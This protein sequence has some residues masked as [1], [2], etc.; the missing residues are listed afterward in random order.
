VKIPTSL[1]F[2]FWSQYLDVLRLD[3]VSKISQQFPLA[4]QT[5][6]RNRDYRILIPPTLWSGM[7]LA[8][9]SIQ[10]LAEDKDSYGTFN[11]L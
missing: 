7:E 11:Y 2:N 8:Y 1:N 6:T 4:S 3:S 5:N 10:E 9:L